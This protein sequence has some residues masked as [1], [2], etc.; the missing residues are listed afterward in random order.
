MTLE[1]RIER[2]EENAQSARNI[3][4]R[5]ADDCLGRASLVSAARLRAQRAVAAATPEELDAV[6]VDGEL[7]EVREL[8]ELEED[9]ARLRRMVVSYADDV[10]EDLHTAQELKNQLRARGHGARVSALIRLIVRECNRKPR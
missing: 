6:E 10:E 5:R 4:Q 8:H 9:L 7:E 1:D 3:R 2:A